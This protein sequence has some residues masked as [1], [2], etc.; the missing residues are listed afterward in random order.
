[1]LEQIQSVHPRIKGMSRS[2]FAMLIFHGA[3]GLYQ[4][5]AEKEVLD[6]K[7]RCIYLKIR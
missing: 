6:V 3:L 5:Y 7:K 2:D 1:M 4:I